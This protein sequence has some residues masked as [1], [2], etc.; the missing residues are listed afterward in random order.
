MLNIEHASEFF[1]ISTHPIVVLKKQTFKGLAPLLDLR[2]TVFATG[3]FNLWPIESLHPKESAFISFDAK[4]QPPLAE[5]G[6]LRRW[7][8]LLCLLKLTAETCPNWDISPKPTKNQ[9]SLIPCSATQKLRPDSWDNLP[10]IWNLTFN[11][12]L[13]KSTES[14]EQV[15]QVE[16]KK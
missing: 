14:T 4:W 5:A 10:S 15:I 12:C 7:T 16:V 6:E 13:R 2:I 1:Q 8:T 11:T 3:L 9:R